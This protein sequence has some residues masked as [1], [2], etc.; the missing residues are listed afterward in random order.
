MGKSRDIGC[1][2][3]D[4]STGRHRLG[5]KVELSARSNDRRVRPKE[6]NIVV[7]QSGRNKKPANTV[8]KRGRIRQCM[9]QGQQRLEAIV[10]YDISVQC[11]FSEG[12][13]FTQAMQSPSSAPDPDI[14]NLISPFLWQARIDDHI[15]SKSCP[16]DTSMVRPYPHLSAYLQICQLMALTL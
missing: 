11:Q 1:R 12:S 4:P 14:H 5:S 15:P 9:N 13:S 8:K 2:S 7:H 16:S 6:Y 3:R 10:I